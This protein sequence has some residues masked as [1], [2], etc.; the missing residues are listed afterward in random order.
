MRYHTCG[1]IELPVT[2]RALQ[3]AALHISIVYM[4]LHSISISISVTIARIVVETGSYLCLPGATK[5]ALV[6]LSGTP[7]D[8]GDHTKPL[9]EEM[10]IEPSHKQ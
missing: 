4:E 1:C 7:G 8:T 9:K 2:Y 3:P 10:N 6:H 5:Q